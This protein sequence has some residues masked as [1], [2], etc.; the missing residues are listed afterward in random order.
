MLEAMLRENPTLAEP[1]K[2][3]LRQLKQVRRSAGEVRDLDVH[4]KLLQQWLGK[5]S[6]LQEGGAD[7]PLARQ[8]EKLDDWLQDER[9]HLAHSML[10]QLKKRQQR[11]AAAE[12]GFQEAILTGTRRHVRLAH[13]A[14]A[15]ALEDFIRVV[16][17]MPHLDAE[18]LHDFRK[19]IKKARYLAESGEETPGSSSVA[20][21]L[22]RVQDAI[23]EWHDWFC[24]Q[25]EATT[26]LEGGAPELCAF[27]KREAERHFVLAMKTTQTMRARLTGEWMA[28]HPSHFKRPAASVRTD[29]RFASGL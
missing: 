24:L 27:L 22:K 11:L 28:M 5:E 4:R 14:D 18:N 26:A 2:A 3:W 1:A 23:G 7:N 9:T 25:Q 12:A 19:Q 13:S 20:Q 17:A 29:R 21:A 15:L 8:A 6:P 10:K 16:D